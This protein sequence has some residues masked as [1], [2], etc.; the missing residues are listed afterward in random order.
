MIASASR[1]K[2]LSIILCR[3]PGTNIHERINFIREVSS[4]VSLPEG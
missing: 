2:A 3:C 4:A 1:P